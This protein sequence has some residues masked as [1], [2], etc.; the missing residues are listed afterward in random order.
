M[1]DPRIIYAWAR[2]V[3][4]TAGD[5]SAAVG[6]SPE[7]WRLRRELDALNACATRLAEA[8]EEARDRGQVIPLLERRRK[9]RHG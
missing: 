7:H 9:A 3:Q 8:A 5:H 2:A 4:I 6:S 1:A